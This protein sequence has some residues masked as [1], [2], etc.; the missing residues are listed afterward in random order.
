MK[1]ILNHNSLEFKLYDTNFVDY[2]HNWVFENGNETELSITNSN[3]VQQHMSW[4]DN[5][6]RLAR[7]LASNN[8]IVARHGLPDRYLYDI[9]PPTSEFLAKTHEQWAQI[10]KEACEMHLP[11]YNAQTHDIYQEINTLLVQIGEQYSNINTS[12]HNIE[13]AYRFFNAHNIEVL[14]PAIPRGDYVIEAADTSFVHDA[15]S[16]PYY[17]IGRPQFEKYMVSGQVTH[18]EIS[19]YD[20]IANRIELTSMSVQDVVPDDYY[21]QCW[22]NNVPV[23]GNYL[24]IA[25]NPNRNWASLGEFIIGNYNADSANILRLQK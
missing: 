25:T 18:T 19:N 7:L 15:I 13:F 16:V 3:V 23:Y 12:V 11:V 6:D 8:S 20:A 1:L 4:I 17:D 5:K 2:W 9:G 10:T 21:N 22:E 14:Q 24:N